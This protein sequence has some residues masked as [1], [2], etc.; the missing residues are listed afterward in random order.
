MNENKLDNIIKE[1]I[2]RVI[3]EKSTRQYVRE[4][5][6][7]YLNEAWED[8][9]NNA[10]DKQQ[11]VQDDEEYRSKPWYKRIAARLSGNRPK[12]PFPNQGLDTMRSQYVKAFND[13]HGFS[14]RYPEDD[15]ASSMRMQYM[16]STGQPVLNARHMAGP[17]YGNV[18]H[19][20]T[21]EYDENGNERDSGLPYPYSENGWSG[22]P[23]E[24]EIGGRAAKDIDRINRSRENIQNTIRNR[25]NRK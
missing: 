7:R 25:K 21:F 15:T 19:G 8:D 12:D 4:A 18:L 13:E 11:F 14:N 20:S 3:S 22:W 23:T 1:S 9:Y 6:R 16:R 5:V 17:E 10:M 24:D 2:S